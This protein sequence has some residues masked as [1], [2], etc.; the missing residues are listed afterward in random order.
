MGLDKT[1]VGLNCVGED[2]RFQK[3]PSRGADTCG[4]VTR[5]GSHSG[6]DPTKK[7]TLKP[8]AGSACGSTAGCPHDSW[9]RDP[10]GCP[11]KERPGHQPRAPAAR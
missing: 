10:G 4:G 3:R 7:D 1:W 5:Q 6:P 8:Q 9:T 2:E 11:N